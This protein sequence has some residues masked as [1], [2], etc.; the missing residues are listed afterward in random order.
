MKI[1]IVKGSGNRHD[2]YVN[3]Y[4]LG[5]YICGE[6]KHY[7]D[8]EKWAKQQLKKRNIVLDRNIERL[9]SELKDLK[10]EKKSINEQNK[11]VI[12]IEEWK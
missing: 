11:T 4:Q 8:P 7:E 2:L 5:E 10:Q 3:G 1:T 6:K 9:E 12:K